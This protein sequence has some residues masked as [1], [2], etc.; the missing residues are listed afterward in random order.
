MLG[1]LGPW[2]KKVLAAFDVDSFFNFSLNKVSLQ[3][4]L[5]KNPSNFPYIF[6]LD[7]IFDKF[8]FKLHFLII[9]FSMLAK[10]QEDKKSITMLL[11]KYLNFKIL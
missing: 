10:F 11:I 4:C 8:T 2:L 5:K 6:L 1:G 7:M 9:I 3:I